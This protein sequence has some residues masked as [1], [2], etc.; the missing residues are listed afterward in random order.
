MYLQ[1]SIYSK[2]ELGKV[3][4]GRLKEKGGIYR[5]YVIY[6]QVLDSSHLLLASLN[7]QI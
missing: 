1:F 4:S 3:E 6:K 7:I 2:S 5:E